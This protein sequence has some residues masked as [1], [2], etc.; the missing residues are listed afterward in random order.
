[1]QKIIE[2]GEIMVND[3]ITIIVPIYKINEEFLKKC[4][5]SLLKQN[6][7]QTKIILIDDGSPDNCGFIC[8]EYAKKNSNIIVV[9]QK[10]K[11]VS[12]SR[13]IGIKMTKTKW[14]TFVD[15]DDWVENY[16]YDKALNILKEIDSDIEVLMFPYNMVYENKIINREFSKNNHILNNEEI[17]ECQKA[18]F[19][20]L[21]QYGK[22]NT[23]SIAALWNKIYKTSFIKDNKI[24]FISKAKKGQDRLFNALVFSNA[25]MIYYNNE[26]KYYYRCYNDSITNKYNEQILNLTMF[27]I[28]EL[29]RINNKYNLN[30]LNFI[31]AR[32][33]TRLFSCMR[34]YF[35]HRNNK[36]SW[37]EKKKEFTNVLEKYKFDEIIDNIDWSLFN[38]N[39]KIFLYCVKHKLYFACLI[40]IKIYN[41]IN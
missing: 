39:E 41:I 24:Y 22:C 8:D 31:N 1:M 36:K 4:I 10:N 25:K 28:E 2:N 18:L 23:Y 29:L 3:E 7:K 21:F 20:K 32:L 37:A 19:Y 27:E 38:K 6:A 16:N 11:G 34:L 13:N 17:K 14:L 15:P 40:F 35:F 9:H 12:E 26:M 33:C 30:F 5:E